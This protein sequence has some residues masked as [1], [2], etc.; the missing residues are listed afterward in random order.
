MGALRSSDLRSIGGGPYRGGDR[1]RWWYM[2]AL[3]S[4][5]L[6]HFSLWPPISSSYLL[7]L[8]LSAPRGMCP[9]PL[10]FPL[11]AGLGGLV[12]PSGPLFLTTP[13]AL[14]TLAASLLRLRI[15]VISTVGS[16][17]K[18]RQ[19]SSATLGSISCPSLPILTG[20]PSFQGL[21]RC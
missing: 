11:P 7:F 8:P 1:I 5:Y 12:P 16:S 13:F 19:S 15:G 3:R 6:P 2:G 14:W 17:G 9:L 18:S 10:G 21:Y 4:S 20:L